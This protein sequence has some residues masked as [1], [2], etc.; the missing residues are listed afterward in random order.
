[1]DHL[2]LVHPWDLSHCSVSP[3]PPLPQVALWSLLMTMDP[4]GKCSGAEQVM[5]SSQGG[6]FIQ[7][8][9]PEDDEVSPGTGPLIPFFCTS[10]LSPPAVAWVQL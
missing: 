1:M 9:I 10:S 4:A 3:P 5:R 6:V 8:E 7:M 2:L